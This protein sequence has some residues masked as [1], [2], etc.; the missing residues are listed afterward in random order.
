M[1]KF[2]PKLEIGWDDLWK[3]VS[4]YY[5]Q[6]IQRKMSRN[7]QN[8]SQFKPF[9]LTI[10]NLF[11]SS[12]EEEL[13]IYLKQAKESLTRAILYYKRGGQPL[14]FI[15]DL[16]WGGIFIGCLPDSD[17]QQLLMTLDMREILSCNLFGGVSMIVTPFLLAFNGKKYNFPAAWL[18]NVLTQIELEE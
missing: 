5:L 12:Q 10:Y 9:Q 13:D 2:T 6:E 17:F 3:G 18:E 8:S 7:S 1:L 14:N 11:K 4:Q 16:L 15:I